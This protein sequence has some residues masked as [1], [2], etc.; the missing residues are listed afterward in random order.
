MDRVAS[1][2]LLWDFSF[3]SPMYEHCSAIFSSIST[4]SCRIG[5][6]N[7]HALIGSIKAQIN[8]TRSENS[9]LSRSDSS[10]LKNLNPSVLHLSALIFQTFLGVICAMNQYTT[11]F[12]VKYVRLSFG[13]FALEKI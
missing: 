5:T 8:Q 7:I 3:Q 13:T 4:P 1:I 11:H 12:C 10:P 6:F 9:D 2:S